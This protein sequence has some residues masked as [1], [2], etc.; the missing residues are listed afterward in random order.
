MTER[1]AS[2][3]RWQYRA[4]NAEGVAV[5]GE[6]D[7][8]SERDAIDTLRRRS[9]WVVEL[10]PLAGSAREAGGAAPRRAE[11]LERLRQSDDRDLAVV[12]RSVATLTG[13]GVPLFRA[14]SYA[15]QEATGQRLRDAFGAVRDAVARGDSLSVAV[16]RHAVFPPMFAPLI[17]AGE[18]SGTLDASLTLLADDLERRQA[19]RSTVTS[20]LVYPSILGAASLIGVVVILAVVVPRFGALIA[21]SGG[22][23]PVSTRALM[24]LSSLLVRGWWVWLLL[25]IGGALAVRYLWRDPAARRRID[26][27]RLG[28]PVIGRL[29]RTQAAASYTGTLAIGLRSGVSL[30][31]SMALARGV[32]A[33]AELAASLRDAEDRVRGGERVASA[34]SGLLPPLAERLLDAGEVSGDLAGLAARAAEAANGELQ[35]AVALAVTLIEPVMILGFGGVVG[36]VALAL[37]QAIYGL[38]ATTM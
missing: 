5:S 16:G 33:N 35:R 15:V 28:W 37:L 14:L 3:A 10:V 12:V 38:N 27:S 21:D 22:Q 8:L 2:R 30:L 17:A 4:A 23:L 13:A 1:V 24:M 9:L 11:F 34:V 25:A 18:A 26:A 32:V 6:I 36:F 31:G 29:E 19:L 7:A 20:A